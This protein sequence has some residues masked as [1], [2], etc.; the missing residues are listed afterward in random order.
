MSGLVDSHCHIPLLAET[1][2]VEEILNEA[3]KHQIIHM[4]CVAIDLEGSPEIIQLA[5]SYENTFSLWT[6]NLSEN[7]TV[8][9]GC[10]F[11]C[12]YSS[13]LLRLRIRLWLLPRPA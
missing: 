3:K 6:R 11:G 4:L 7:W 2:S 13:G 12:G 5:K 10:G 8:V 1:Q 9:T